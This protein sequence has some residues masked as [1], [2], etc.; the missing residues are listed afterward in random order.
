[1][2]I[3]TAYMVIRLGL[4]TQLLVIIECS[5]RTLLEVDHALH[6]HLVLWQY[7]NLSSMGILGSPTIITLLVLINSFQMFSKSLN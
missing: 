5:H 6:W 7:Q 3:Q 2:L 1:M 4:D